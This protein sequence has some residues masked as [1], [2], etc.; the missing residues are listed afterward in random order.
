MLPIVARSASGRWSSPGAVELDELADDAVLAQH[1]G[2]RQ[3]QVGGRHALLQR[4]GQ[5]EA[6]HLGDQHR[7][8]LAQHRRLGL[9][10]ADAP[11]EHRQAVDHGRV[12]VG[13]DQRVRDRRP[14]RRS[15]PCRSRPPGRDI[16][17]SPGGRCRCPAARRGNCRTRPGPISGTDSA[18]RCARI[19]A[20]RSAGT[21]ADCRTR[22]PSPSGRSPGRHGF[23]GLIFSGSP[24]SA[25]I[26]SR[27]AARSTTAGTPVKSCISTRAGR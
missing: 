1:L 23:S 4:A 25:T 5:L 2:D 9:D 6:D 3:H 12:A 15:G 14:R 19:R 13:A 10:A 18:R 11:A 24:P 7:D 17:G 26:A 16:P 20:R 21:R 8:R 22:R 27:I